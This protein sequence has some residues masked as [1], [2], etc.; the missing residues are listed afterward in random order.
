MKM[1]IHRGSRQIGG[2]VTELCTDTTRIFIDFGSELPGN[3]EAPTAP[4]SIPG[5]T[6]G[7]P[8]CDG[9]F[10]THT[11]SDHIGEM[12]RVDERIPLYLGRVGRELQ[13]TLCR[14]LQESGMDRAAELRALERAR[15]LVPGVAV[16]T[17]DLRVTPLLIDHSAFDAYMFLIEGDGLRVLHTGD[18]RSHGFRGKGLRP[19]LQKYVG[20]V[21]WLICEGT[22]LSRPETRVMTERQLQWKARQ[23]MKKHKR[24]FVLCSSMNIDRIAA[25]VH[26]VP[27]R[28]VVVCDEYQKD[29]LQIVQRHSARYSGLYRFDRVLRYGRNLDGPMDKRGFL[30]FVRANRYFE[31]L[32]HRFGEGAEVVY[33]LWDGYLEGTT[34]NEGYLRLLEGRSWQSLHTSGHATREALRTVAE[35]VR[36]R[37]GII[38]IHTEQPGRFPA[39]MEG[40]SVKTVEDGVAFS[41]G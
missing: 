12:E 25:F 27:D 8:R 22:M 11:H 20:Q 40:F 3:D 41:L 29:L 14:R 2:C 1:T 7:E 28:R 39:L 6:E 35:I 30:F 4:L 10:F 19:M 37:C 38:P 26:A 23:L 15:P 17:G 16:R 13:L 31:Q 33:S 5:L 9:V 36:P 34:K 32:M 18:F 24:V 21:D